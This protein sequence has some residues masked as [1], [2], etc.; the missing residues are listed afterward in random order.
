M[1]SCAHVSRRKLILRCCHLSAILPFA[2]WVYFTQLTR[3][4]FR[5]NAFDGSD[6]LICAAA[7]L[8]PL[9]CH[10]MLLLLER[11]WRIAPSGWIFSV[12]VFTV[13]ATGWI[14]TCAHSFPLWKT[15]FNTTQIVATQYFRLRLSCILGLLCALVS[16]LPAALPLRP[17]PA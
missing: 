14:Y 2:G 16:M 6:F 11:R 13:T 3:N 7:A 17:K 12:T 4:T 10:I 1:E 5:P 8:L 15:A 9:L